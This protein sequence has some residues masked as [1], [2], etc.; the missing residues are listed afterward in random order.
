MYDYVAFVNLCEK[1]TVIS[2]ARNQRH[3]E[4]GPIAISST[5]YLRL[6]FHRVIDRP[7]AAQPQTIHLNGKKAGLDRKKFGIA[8][9]VSICGDLWEARNVTSPSRHHGV[10]E[11]YFAKQERCLRLTR[12]V[13]IDAILAFAVKTVGCGLVTATGTACLSF[14][15]FP[16]WPCELQIGSRSLVN[17]ALP[18]NSVTKSIH[19]PLASSPLQH[20]SYQ[21]S[22]P[23][24]SAPSF[25]APGFH[26]RYPRYWK[27][28][29]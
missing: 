10:C 7:S 20:H 24:I 6:A 2:T 5:T 27:S 18:Q 9:L 11:V 23:D 16:F 25:L 28:N 29:L 3:N 12:Y 22:A 15:Q 17:T 26:S 13:R 1:V 21:A 14:Y 8:G 4:E 19:L